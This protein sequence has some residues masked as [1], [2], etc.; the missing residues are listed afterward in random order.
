MIAGDV[1]RIIGSSAPKS[2]KSWI[3]IQEVHDKYLC[4]RKPGRSCLLFKKGE[5]ELWLS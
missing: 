4:Q 1:V 5:V 2:D 3:F